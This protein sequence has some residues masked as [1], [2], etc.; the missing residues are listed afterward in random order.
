MRFTYLAL[1]IL[2]GVSTFAQTGSI[3][4]KITDSKTGEEIIGANVAIQGTSVGDAT[5]LDGKYTIANVK[6]G[7]YSLVISFLTYKTHTIPDVTVESGKITSVNVGMQE[8]ATELDE[9]VVQG[10]REINN[11]FALI[12]AIK[13]SKLVVSGISAEQIVRIPDRDAAQIMQRVPG[14]SIVD[15][16]FVMI[17]GVSER[18]NQV[19]I[20]R[21]IG[22]STEVDKRSFSFDLIPA[23]ALDQLLI[24]K[25]GSPELP[26]DFAGGVIQV[27][28]KKAP[29]ENYFKI[30]TAV[31]YRFNTTGKDYSSSQGSPTDKFGF[32]NGF[33]ALPNQFPT[34]QQLVSS[35][36]TSTLREQ[37]GRS[38]TNNFDYSTTQTPIDFGMNME[39]AQNF[40]IAKTRISTITNLMYSNTYL[41]K[42]VAFNR[43]LFDGNDVETRFAYQDN[44]YTNDVRISG[45]SNWAIVFNDRHKLAFNNLFNLLGENQTILRDGQDL[46]LNDDRFY[47]NYAYMYQSRFIY[48]GQLEGTHKFMDNSLTLEW[49][50]GY[51]FINRDEP[52]LR[53][54]RTFRLVSSGEET[55][56]MQLPPSAN[57]FETGRFYSDLTDKGISNGINLEKK[58]GDV[59]NKRA[60]TLRAGYY[61]ESKTRDFS[62]RYVSYLYPGFFDPQVGEELIRLPL[63]T[64]FAPENIRSQ[65]GFV[66]E[67]G[68]RPSDTYRGENL[69]IA[70]YV[71]GSLPIGKFDI[72]GGFRLESNTQRIETATTSGPVIIENPVISPMP[73][74]N[75]AYNLT[76]RSLVR[77]AYSR[78]VNRP[79][80]RELAP[81]LYYDFELELGVFG[82][83]NLKVADIDNIDLRWEMYP[84]PGEL[85]SVGTFYKSFRNPIESI[86][87]LTAESPQ[88]TY[89]NADK[90]F[91]YGAEFELRKSLASLGVSKFLRNMAVNLNASY[92]ISEVD[93][94]SQAGFQQQ[95]RELQGQ[96]P[97]IFNTGLY[98]ADDA[99]DFSVS[100]AYNIFGQRIFQVGDINF[101]SVYELPR[102]Q[103]DMQ[104][105]KVFGRLETKLNIQN[106][107]NAEFRFYQDTDV[108][109]KIDV[110]STDAPILKYKIGQQISFNMSYKISK[111]KPARRSPFLL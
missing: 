82:N 63:S 9:I 11:D 88:S 16:R 83:P 25:S 70:G 67:E 43:F 93:L 32:D 42:E 6:P 12:N 59:S 28:T 68:T 31:G 58:F 66:I 85:I 48:S 111:D 56:Q 37:A 80:F 75:T 45:V 22:P 100:V 10:T 92:I 102:N 101:P 27:L 94:G 64:I 49:V 21:A 79:E 39:L 107:L 15:N 76:D 87:Q 18:Y 69:L 38:L 65:D 86:L 26:G 8:D 106:L 4:G 109:N 98:Y 29:A 77:V 1:F 33:R 30:G 7:T 90:A 108:N 51:N 34:T 84:N 62:A 40:R 54:F 97:Y 17:R 71:G 61:V 78:T 96:S 99:K 89:G 52:D 57:L 81:F 5:N 19:M 104:I 60:A 103:L 46:F 14:I 13:E 95:K 23:G 36:R 44:Y 3:T 2:I 72:A 105:S 35:S 91:A 24:Y 110:N 53:R 74:L 20:N 41:N 55:Y 50:A 73:F 47:R